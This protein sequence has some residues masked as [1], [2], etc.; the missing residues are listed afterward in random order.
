MKITDINVVNLYYAYPRG[1]GFQ[2]AGGVATGRLTSLV[3]V[4]TDEG[5][6]GIGSAYS[7]PDMVR[8]VVEGNLRDLLT[9]DDPTEV[10]ALWHKMYVITRWYGR[11]GAA[12][13]A[14]G[15]VDTA[16]WDIRGKALGVPVCEMLGAHRDSVPAYA[17]ALLWKD[18]QDLAAEA[19]SYVQEGYRAV[20]MRLG[21]N[22]DEDRVAV[23]AV[24]DAVGSEVR[25]MV[26]GSMR[27]PPE[28]ALR[29]ARELE[30]TGVFWFEEPFPPE[31]VDHFAE[32]RSQVD[33]P[34]AAG[35]NE[36][37][38]QGF[39]ELIR[40]GAVD[41]VQ[42]DCSRSGGIT[43][44][45][46]IGRAAEERG[47]RVATHTW[48]DAVAI[49]AN[50]HLVA[51]LP[52]GITVEVDR[53]GNPFIDELLTEPLVVQEGEIA[54]PTG[55]GLGIELDEDLIDAYT[56]PPDAP[57]PDGNYADM[58]YGR[59]HYAAIPPYGAP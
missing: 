52:N 10:S 26:D 29:I 2:Y 33:V 43:E 31:E 14:L 23:R 40:M 25:V 47:L 34:L 15:A 36:F 13:S 37:G 46:R 55:P 56:L 41:I 17:S 58:V 50:M 12:M 27:Y 18:P 4:K 32:L 42:P 7:N 54:L 53:T 28:A 30:E 57:I 16:L 21:R 6:E 59:E 22:W 44:C 1:G 19:A 8:C 3:R 45:R 39:G 20:K 49:V 24:R 9:G 11:K 51:S 35:E 38:L 5:I 48:S